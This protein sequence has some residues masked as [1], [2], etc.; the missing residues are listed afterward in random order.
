[1]LRIL[2]AA[3]IAVFAAAPNDSARA[4]APPGAQTKV[5]THHA[6]SLLG[7]PK[8]G[9]DFRALDYVNV[10]APKGGEV[11]LI[12]IGG[13]DSLNP[14]IIKGESAP[15]IG[16]I[17]ETLMTSTS[18]DATSEYGLIAESVDVPDDLSWVAFK[19]RPGARWHDGKPITAD[20]VVWSFDTLKEKGA[21]AYRFYY[22]NVTKA[23]RLAA[24]RVK[25]HFSGP[26][27]RELPQIMGQLPV[28]PKHS[29]ANRDF[30][31]TTL[32]P[33]LGSGP[34]R[35]K[36]LEP[37]RSIIYERVADHWG[38][39]LALNRGRNNY[40]LVRY[41]MYRDTTVALEAFKA[42]Q[43]DFRSENSAKNWA[44]AYD[45]P[46]VT[47]GQA[48]KREV[49][50][51]RPTGMQAFAFNL[52]RDKFADR[53][54]RQA[55]GYAFDFEWASKNL[56]FGQYV[57]T[58]SYFSNSDLAATGQPGP[59]ELKL[60]EPLRAQL[61]PEAF[62]PAYAPPA[63]DGS[64]DLRDNL[65]K[66]FALLKD[67]GWTVKDKVLTGPGGAK[68]EIE[69]LLAS[70]EFE[71][72]VSPYARNLERL[73]VKAA[74]RTVDSAQYQ[75]RVREFD[76]DVIVANFAQSESPGN[77][78]REYWS[79]AAAGRP[80]SR[81]VIGIKNL[82]IDAL[83][84]AVIAAPDRAGLVAATR[85]LDRALTWG[86][87]VVPHWHLT[88]DRI[89]YWNRFGMPAVTPKYGVDLFAW[90]IDPAKDAAL[91][92]GN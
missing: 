57:R 12:D 51:G 4:A 79:S 33:P 71:R 22:A 90:W 34:Y 21:P 78:Q 52:R 60:L 75:N 88:V 5:T 20:D 92:K 62:G 72:I 14:Y 83:V 11:R 55:L 8:Y 30:D 67:A 28:L 53:R 65:R 61:P 35:V 10:D 85:A 54:V 9:P 70:P 24:D 69:F 74:I 40:D 91:K 77:E 49:R 84:D 56:F 58:A 32:E 66:A 80:G 76:F 81:N 41:D 26:K 42:R 6:L 43:Y 44:T 48:I 87:Y 29:F 17:Y 45:L 46:A 82:G 1:M 37:N 73:G 18:D 47:Q 38:K 13:Y 27:N 2:T 19:L 16:L 64:G 63:T 50:H 39:D 86:H 89:A 23:E 7:E 68:M 59:A 3:L 25:F 36:S 31:K 15:G